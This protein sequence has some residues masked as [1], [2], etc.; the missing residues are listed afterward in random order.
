MLRETPLNH[1]L[2]L[3]CAQVLYSTHRMK[4]LS[5]FAAQNTLLK[6]ICGESNELWEYR[7]FKISLL[8]PVHFSSTSAGDNPEIGAVRSHKKA[9]HTSKWRRA[10]FGYWWHIPH[11]IAFSGAKAHENGMKSEAP[12]QLATTINSQMTTAMEA[13]V[14]NKFTEKAK[15]YLQVK[16]ESQTMQA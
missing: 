2:S 1:K 7:T 9:E 15:K 8:I 13:L 6:A 12:L 5:N 4:Y 16:I 14:T 3:K 10:K 11:N